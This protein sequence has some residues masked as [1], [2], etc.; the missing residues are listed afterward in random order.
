[1]KKLI[2]IAALLALTGFGCAKP[3]EDPAAGF[4]E[5]YRNEQ[6][7]FGF[8]HAPD[9]NVRVREEENRKD[10]YVGKDADFFVSIRDVV[11]EGEKEP[12]NLAYVYAIPNLT[13]AQFKQ[14]FLE[15]NP[16]SAVTD[17][18]PAT[19]N[20]VTLQR[21]VNTTQMGEDKIHYLLPRADGTLIIFSVFIREED[22]LKPILETLSAD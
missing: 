4:S 13:P 21:M 3:A 9:I 7:G 6:Y 18:A 5:T 17:L 1:M 8:R 14:A 15:S 22:N 19:F 12:L 11:R 2:A 10:A 20:G 16:D